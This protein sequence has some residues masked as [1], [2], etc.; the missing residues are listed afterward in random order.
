MKLSIIIP[1]Y[2]EIQTIDEILR[3]VSQVALEVE[4]E[5]VIVDDCSSDGTREHLAALRDRPGVGEDLSG[6]ARQAIPGRSS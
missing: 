2:N 1:C 4:R 6:E 3:K 5:I